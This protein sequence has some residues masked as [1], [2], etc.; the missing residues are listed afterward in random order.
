MN[1]CVTELAKWIK[2]ILSYKYL[3][4]SSGGGSAPC[5]ITHN[6]RGRGGRGEDG[7][8]RGLHSHAG[9]V[10]QGP[11]PQVVVA[12]V[13]EADEGEGQGGGERRAEA[14]LPRSPQGEIDVPGGAGAHV[15]R[16]LSDKGD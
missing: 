16:G 11:D 10:H 5:G 9:P 8:R 3:H 1:F 12:A 15:E 2:A 14:A 6:Q 13:P 7:S 4:V